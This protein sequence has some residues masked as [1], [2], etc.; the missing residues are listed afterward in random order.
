MRFLRDLSPKSIIEHYKAVL[1]Y[2]D[3]IVG[4]GIN[5]N[6]KD[7]PPAFF[8]EACFLAH[9]D[10]FKFTIHCDVDSKNATRS[11]HTIISERPQLL[12]QAMGLTV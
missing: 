6:E 3:M 2:S 10:G 9:R 5:L 1:P 4:V 8:D 12:L 11:M 7:R